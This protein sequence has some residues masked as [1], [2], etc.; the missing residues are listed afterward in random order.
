M[1]TE[2]R[3]PRALAALPAPVRWLA[4][5]V[6]L[7]CAVVAL[8]G[9]WSAPADI[10]VP[11]PTGKAADY[12]RNLAAALPQDLLGHARKD[13]TPSS[14]FVAAW[15]SSPR[16][17]L[18]CGVDRPEELDGEHAGDWSPVAEEVTWW[19]QKLDDDSYRFVSTMRKAYVE[20]TVPR[21]VASNP[22][23][24]VAA[25][26]GAVRANVPG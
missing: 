18:R 1:P 10:A 19:A 13:P 24:P 23:D 16:T 22:F 14:P 7:T 9:S 8:L 3:V 6:V 25:L 5:P 15:G 17:V 4:A 21:G 20:V 11:A 26:S 12:C 2:L